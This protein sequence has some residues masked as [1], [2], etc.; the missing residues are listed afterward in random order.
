[1]HGQRRFLGVLDILS[2]EPVSRTA[3]VLRAGEVLRV[4]RDQLKLVL[5]TD[6]ELRELVLRAYLARP[7]IGFEHSADLHILEHPGSAEV[8]R[9]QDYAD[10]NHLQP[11]PPGL[12]LTKGYLGV[13]LLDRRSVVRPA[14]AGKTAGEATT[15]C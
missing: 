14:P 10:A 15:R 13:D 5:A 6:A 8:R 12:G 2:S 11:S 4:P 9:L 7:A 1:M 3:V